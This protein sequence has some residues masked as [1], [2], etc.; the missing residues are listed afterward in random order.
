MEARQVEEAIAQG[1]SQWHQQQLQA[2]RHTVRDDQ[3]EW[4]FIAPVGYG[5]YAL[6]RYI[7]REDFE[8]VRQ[9]LVRYDSDFLEEMDCFGL[10]G[11]W[12]AN[13]EADA[14]RV[15][16]ILRER[17]TQS[18][19]LQRIWEDAIIAEA[20]HQQTQNQK[21]LVRELLQ[22]RDRL[23]GRTHEERLALGGEYINPAPPSHEGMD[24]I[25]GRRFVLHGQAYH[26]PGRGQNIY[27][28]GEWFVVEKDP[29]GT[30]YVWHVL[31]NGRD[32]DDWSKNNVDTGGAGAIGYRYPLTDERRA[33][34][35]RLASGSAD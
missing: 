16:T 19:E 25:L 9:H 10:R 4:A 35:E 27:G 13:S 12:Y 32:G 26:I 3:I 24:T 6:R 11:G 33:F 21:E 7:P 14:R 1:R 15:E 2:A 31:N 23:F 22:E 20:R 29:S 28:G 18:R 5:L 8:A 34:L 17:I 30:E